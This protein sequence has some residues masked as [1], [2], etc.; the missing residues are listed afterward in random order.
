M[1]SASILLSLALTTC[2]SSTSD[3][4][5]ATPTLAPPAEG[6]GFQFSMEATVEPFSEAWICRSTRLKST[7]PPM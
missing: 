5:T 2:S 7:S 6:E 4:A 3:T 1:R